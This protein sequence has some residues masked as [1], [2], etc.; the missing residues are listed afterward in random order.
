MASRRMLAKQIVDSDAFLDMPL[1]TQAYYFHLNIRADDDGFINN[2]KKIM[3]L[4]GANQ[5]DYDL[6]VAKN[7]IIEFEAGVVVIKHW[8]IHNYIQKD[9]YKPT[10]YQDQF[11]LL[12]IKKNKS[13]TLKPLDTTCIQ[14]VSNSDTQSSLVQ[15]SLEDKIID[16]HFSNNFLTDILF[17]LGYLTSTDDITLVEKFNK[18]FSEL[19]E[20]VHKNDAVKI[21]KYI[22]DRTKNKE[23]TNKLAYFITSFE[24]G[25]RRLDHSRESDSDDFVKSSLNLLEGVKE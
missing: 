5:N 22:C 25:L 14:N 12:T 8:R 9:R 20:H 19:L 11:A 4:I 3:R 21:T 23:I 18:Y 10:V 6:L 17:E 15:V 16:K 2:P 24:E 7:F 13:Y 1:S